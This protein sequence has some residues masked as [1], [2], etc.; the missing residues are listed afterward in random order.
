MDSEPSPT[1]VP[2]RRA[3]RPEKERR[4]ESFHSLRAR[5]ILGKDS[6]PLFRPDFSVGYVPSN[7]K[8]SEQRQINEQRSE[9]VLLESLACQSPTPIPRIMYNCWVTMTNH[10]VGTL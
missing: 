5:R 2:N 7:A 9:V 3:D 1:K 8:P 10:L 6:R 4:R